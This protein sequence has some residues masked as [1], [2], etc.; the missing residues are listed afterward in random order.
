MQECTNVF[1]SGGGEAMANEFGI[2][3]LGMYDNLLEILT[4]LLTHHV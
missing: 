4:N 2:D 3:F 1:S